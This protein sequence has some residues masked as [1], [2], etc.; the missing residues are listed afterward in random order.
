MAFEKYLP[1]ALFCL[2]LMNIQ[3]LPAQESTV[4]PAARPALHIDTPVA[5]KASK[6]VFN[7]DHL[8]FAGDQPIGL[9]HMKTL[10]Q[11]Y[12]ERHIPLELIAVFHG[13]AGYMLLND[14]AF[15][16]A[17]KSEKGNPYKEQIFALQRRGVQFEECV[18]T[19]KANGWT[20]ADLLAGV[21]VNAGANLRLIQLMQD[22]YV[23]LHP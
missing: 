9:T 4:Q 2:A 23:Q 22:G 20:N 11:A 17:R 12:E 14:D 5:V 3:P 8:A 6:V 10:T 16:R 19:A 18:N 15:D 7:M 13:A 21:K 1:P